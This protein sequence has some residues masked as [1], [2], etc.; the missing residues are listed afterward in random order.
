MFRSNGIYHSSTSRPGMIVGCGS[1]R[2]WH[3]R[4]DVPVRPDV[5]ETLKFELICAEVTSVSMDC[6]PQRNSR[7]LREHVVGPK[8]P[9]WRAILPLNLRSSMNTN[10]FSQEELDAQ[11][12]VEL[13]AR[14]LLITVS[15][16][17]LPLAGVDGVNANI[18]TRGPNWLFGSVGQV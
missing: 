5:D 8:C 6:S 13:P 4:A 7:P 17:G 18:D 3:P 14:D 16:L 10:D 11:Q 2:A 12:A 15:V 1:S 9:W